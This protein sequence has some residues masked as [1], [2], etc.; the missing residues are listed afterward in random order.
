M[1]IYRYKKSA[2]YIHLYMIERTYVY[3]YIRYICIDMCEICT[4]GAAEGEGAPA[5]GLCAT[6][7]K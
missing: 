1:Y 5:E 3:I 4:G 7:S 6:I 2:A